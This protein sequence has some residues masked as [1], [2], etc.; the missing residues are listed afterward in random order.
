MEELL[1]ETA[2][3][4]YC[5]HEQ[6]EQNIH[7]V[8]TIPKQTG[9]KGQVRPAVLDPWYGLSQ[10]IWSFGVGADEVRDF[11]LKN[12]LWLVKRESKHS[13]LGL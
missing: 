10:L 7:L 3:Y 4:A 9:G 5:L 11:A 1:F 13:L 2:D 8:I 12:W 6:R